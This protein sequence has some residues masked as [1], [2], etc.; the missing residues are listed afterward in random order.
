MYFVEV[1]EFLLKRLKEIDFDEER[2]N[3]LRRFTQILRVK[4]PTMVMTKSGLEIDKSYRQ[5]G[6][7][8]K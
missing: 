3:E 1:F 5:F 2:I 6:F 4:H 8:K 7:D